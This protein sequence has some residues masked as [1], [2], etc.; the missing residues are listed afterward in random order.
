MKRTRV[1]GDVD[2]RV[3]WMIQLHTPWREGQLECQEFELRSSHGL[4]TFLCIK[5][6]RFADVES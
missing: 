4:S 2:L 5:P 1:H 6:Y 3:W